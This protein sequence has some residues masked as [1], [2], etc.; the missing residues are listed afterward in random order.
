MKSAGSKKNSTSGMN[1][2]DK[3]FLSS[4]EICRII[5]VCSKRGVSYFEYGHLSIEL[6]N[7]E[8]VPAINSKKISSGNV[9]QEQE[10][11]EQTEL[12][13]EEIKTREEQ[14]AELMITD[15]LTAE[16]MIE[17]GELE[18]SEDDDES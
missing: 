9:L 4:E 15:P 1:F 3:P 8:A 11:I 17:R 6:T 14:I 10:K 13:A 16:E 12:L 5:E 2:M 18:E 7:R